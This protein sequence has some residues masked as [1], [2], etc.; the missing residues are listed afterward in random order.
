M[1]DSAA[2]WVEFAVRTLPGG[3]DIG[4]CFGE[5]LADRVSS[6]ATNRLVTVVGER[7]SSAGAVRVGVRPRG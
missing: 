6:A 2:A 4:V 7:H 5:L 1:P 3:D